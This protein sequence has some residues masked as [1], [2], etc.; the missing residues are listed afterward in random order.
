[1]RRLLYAVILGLLFLAPCERMDVAKLLPIE[2][3]AVYMEKGSVIL[4]TDTENKGRGSNATEALQN[5]KD[6]TPAVVYLD[7]A[8]YLLVSEEAVTCVE[9][10]RGFLKPSVKV[11]VCEA[12]G[13]VKTAAK[14]LEVHEKLPKLRDW[15]R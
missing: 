2:A 6:V 11:C 5:L 9:E 1:M 13:R 7:T 14:Y 12:A 4:E 8:E 3:V 10:L 15:N